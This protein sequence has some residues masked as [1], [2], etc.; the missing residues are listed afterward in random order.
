[1]E[2]T[3]AVDQ[4]QIDAGRTL[5]RKLTNKE[6]EQHALLGMVSEVGEIAGLYQKVYQGHPLDME[7]VEKE[8]GDL[9]WFVSE[10]CY[11]HGWGLK[12]VMRKN[13]EKLRARYPDGFDAEHSLHR[14]EGDV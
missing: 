2:L 4:Y 8:L 12:D 14:A 9:C 11:A 5:N 3:N 7:H 1:M 6:M 13:I 10:F